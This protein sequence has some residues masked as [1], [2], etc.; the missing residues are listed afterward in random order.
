MVQ[1]RRPVR[2]EPVRDRVVAEQVAVAVAGDHDQLADAGEGADDQHP[3]HHDPGGDAAV[4]PGPVMVHGRL[5]FCWLEVGAGLGLEA[6]GHRVGHRCPGG[7]AG[8]FEG[9]GGDAQ[10]GDAERPG[11]KHVG[12][13]VHAEQQAA[14]ADRGDQRGGRRGERA[15]P[16]PAGRGQEDQEQGAVA[17]D[18]A[19]RVPAG[20]A[21]AVPVSDRVGDHR[22]QPAD[23]Y[24]EDGVKRQRACPG[25]QQVDRE[26]PAA[27]DREHHD[28]QPDQRP[29]HAAAAEPGDR[30]DDAHHRGLAGDEAVQPGR[31][32]VIGRL[33]RRPPQPH[34]DKQEREDE[35][36]HGYDGERCESAPGC[37]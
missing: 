10:P 21:V 37:G 30:L 1:R 8:Q 34:Q 22:A 26:P 28:R 19:E 4:L 31:R 13:V 11:A 2:G 5:R 15:A 36:R 29:E 7:L 12:K 20:E 16:R 9:E 27:P 14:D 23:Q 6:L 35:R 3:G 33:E 25:D 32:V 24:L 17:D 18:R